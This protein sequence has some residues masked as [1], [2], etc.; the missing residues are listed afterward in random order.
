M[1]KK[2]ILSGAILLSTA[3]STT[4]SFADEQTPTNLTGI[5]VGGSSGLVVNTDG[6]DG[7]FRGLPMTVSAGFGGMT[8]PNVYLAG[9]IFGTLLTPSINDAGSVKTTYGYGV[10]FI[11]GF[12]ISEST[13]TFLRLGLIKT[14]FDRMRSV[15]TGGQFGLGLQTNLSETL[16]VRGEYDYAHYTGSLTSDQFNFG[17]I[18]KFM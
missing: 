12:T 3:L 16:A 5:Y 7:H 11:P 6:R 1:L 13:M 18:Y 8:N 4:A 15:K 2:I 14:R 10:S 17:L 9:E